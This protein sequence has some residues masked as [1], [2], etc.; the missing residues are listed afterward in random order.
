MGFW[1][2]LTG[3]TYPYSFQQVKLGSDL[4]GLLDFW[5][6]GSSLLLVS[7]RG[8]LLFGSFVG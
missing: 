7:L 4:T 2:N 6:G 5:V 8:I 3:E 1:L